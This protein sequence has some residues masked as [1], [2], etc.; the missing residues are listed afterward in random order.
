MLQKFLSITVL[1]ALLLTLCM[2]VVS[3]AGDGDPTDASGAVTTGQNENNSTSAGESNSNENNSNENNSNENNSNEK[4]TQKFGG[5][6][7]H[8]GN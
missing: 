3:C 4:D 5:F 7:F 2:A 1:L 8:F 6:H